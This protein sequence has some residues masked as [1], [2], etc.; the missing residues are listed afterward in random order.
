MVLQKGK[1]IE[2]GNHDSLL[3]NYPEGTYAKLVGSQKDQGDQEAILKAFEE[4]EQRAASPPVNVSDAK[5]QIAP[6][7]AKANGPGEPQKYEGL[8]PEEKEKMLEADQNEKPILEQQEAE[9]KK[10]QKTV[11]S[12]LMK[13]SKPYSNVAIGF[14]FATVFGTLFPLLGWLF[15]E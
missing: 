10:K 12:R 7:A 3:K 2:E 5:V 13:Y 4:E 15:V 6:D 8:E 14:F 1:I 9:F 11:S